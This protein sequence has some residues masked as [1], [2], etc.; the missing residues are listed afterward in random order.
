MSARGQEDGFTLFELVLTCSLVLVIG[1]I[2]VP[3][4]GNALTQ[5][6]LSGDARGVAN[7]ISVA[8][9]RAAA[10]FTRTRVF[11]D[12]SDGTY[13][14]ET[15]DKD[16]GTWETSSGTTYLSAGNSFG[17]E[18]I[19]NAPP[20]SQT[21]IDQAP[22]CLDDDGEA[23]GNSAC[24]IFNS[25]GIPVDTTNTPTVADALYVTNGET[26][27][28]ATVSAT[29]LIRLWRAQAAAAASWM[30]Q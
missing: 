5:F 26:V 28:G 1:A 27:F 20:N 4:T 10:H 13:H 14:L 24:V 23:I 18:A 29:G 3:M 30:P 2:S 25:R 11:V 7:T 15:F 6:K 8:K 21:E 22:L 9:M 17:L 12:L 16:A 19:E